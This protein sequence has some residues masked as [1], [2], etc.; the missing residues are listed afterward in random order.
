MIEQSKVSLAEKC[1]ILQVLL[2]IFHFLSEN[3]LFIII[4]FF[5]N[6]VKYYKHFSRVANHKLLE[7]E[8][9]CLQL[10]FLQLA[11]LKTLATFLSCGRYSELLLVP[12]AVLQKSN[13]G[14]DKDKVTFLDI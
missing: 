2:V 9:V 10:A 6:I 4:L 1:F 11:A 12:N 7:C 13:D 5:K 8:V 14:T 3:V